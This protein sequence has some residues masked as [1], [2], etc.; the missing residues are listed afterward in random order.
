MQNI[1]LVS[2]ATHIQKWEKP[3]IVMG[4]DKM[5]A[6]SLLHFTIG[7]MVMLTNS[8]VKSQHISE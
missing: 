7:L 1:Y 4:C 3:Q 2:R 5:K 8:G 6:V